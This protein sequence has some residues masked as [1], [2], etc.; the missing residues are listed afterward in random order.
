MSFVYVTLIRCMMRVCA[1]LAERC[2]AAAHEHGTQPHPQAGFE[3]EPMVSGHPTPG[4][5]KCSARH[6]RISCTEK[7]I[8]RRRHNCVYN[9]RVNRHVR[10]EHSIRSSSKTADKQGKYSPQR[11]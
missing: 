1:A 11:K 3:S 9:R 6:V 8:A 5:V 4:S 7:T 10:G 2:A